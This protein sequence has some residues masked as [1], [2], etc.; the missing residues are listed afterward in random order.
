[1]TRRPSSTL[2]I[3][4]MRSTI[5]ELC[6]KWSDVYDTADEDDYLTKNLV[7]EFLED[8]EWARSEAKATA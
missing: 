2:G 1:M 4:S 7:S 6:E 8:L 3:P 5:T